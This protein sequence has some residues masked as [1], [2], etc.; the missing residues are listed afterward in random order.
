[1]D[2]STSTDGDGIL[3]DAKEGDVVCGSF[4]D[5][6]LY[7]VVAQAGCCVVRAEG[8]EADE[9]GCVSGAHCDLY[10][11][12]VCVGLWSGLWRLERMRKGS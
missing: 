5:A 11:L 9:W 1:M 12:G 10:L 8:L 3:T 6:A 2:G 4:F 7:F